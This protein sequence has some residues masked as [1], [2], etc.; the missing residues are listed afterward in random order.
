MTPIVKR[1]GQRVERQRMCSQRILNALEMFVKSTENVGASGCALAVSGL[2]N[3][4]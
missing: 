4:L 1:I 3:V 2:D